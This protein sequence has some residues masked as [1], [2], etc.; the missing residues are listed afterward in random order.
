MC[1]WPHRL[2][3]CFNFHWKVTVRNPLVCFLLLGHKLFYIECAFIRMP[4]VGET[5]LFCRTV[6]ISR[7]T[8]KPTFAVRSTGLFAYTHQN[9]T[10]C[11]MFDMRQHLD[12]AKCFFFFSFQF[13]FPAGA[14][15]MLFS[16]RCVELTKHCALL[17]L[18]SL[19]KRME[20]YFW[21]CRLSNKVRRSSKLLHG[22]KPKE[23]RSCFLFSQGCRSFAFY[24]ITTGASS[25]LAVVMWRQ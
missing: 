6:R 22:Q 10:T 16:I 17:Q 19:V 12:Y 20:K 5:R 25:V 4:S 13:F 8:S 9:W 2:F 3:F 21:S 7:K 18:L 23:N 1:F 15:C 24:Y 14:V 11:A